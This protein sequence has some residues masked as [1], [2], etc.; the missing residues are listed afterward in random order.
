MLLLVV[1]LAFAFI[2]ANAQPVVKKTAVSPTSPA[3]GEVMFTTY[4]AVCH[5]KAGK[6][7]G[8]AAAALKKTPANLRSR[9]VT[10]FS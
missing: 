2:P 4:C 1:F 10:R 7:D 9:L 5:G 3:S 8:P 6:G